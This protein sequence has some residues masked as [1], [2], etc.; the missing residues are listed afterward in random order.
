[1]R[2]EQEGGTGGQA[3]PSSL[4]LSFVGKFKL[5]EQARD[6]REPVRYF[7]S[8]EEVASVFPDRIFVMEAITFSVKV[9]PCHTRPGVPTLVG[10]LSL[11][12][13]RQKVSQCPLRA[14]GHVRRA[15]C[16]THW[17]A[18]LPGIGEVCVEGPA[19]TWRSSGQPVPSVGR[20]VVG[21]TQSRQ[22]PT[23]VWM[24]RFC[25]QT[26]IHQFIPLHSSLE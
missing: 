22:T 7:S 8:V 9:S 10:G 19:L 17:P 24:A 14:L 1:M 6:V 12:S 25:L 3:C 5:L 20:V 18:E 2:G 21:G 11:G 4:C 13:R 16:M 23:G 15:R 26:L